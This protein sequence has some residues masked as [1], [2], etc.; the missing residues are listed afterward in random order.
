[1]ALDGPQIQFG[2]RHTLNAQDRTTLENKVLPT[3]CKWVRDFP[4]LR[5]HGIQ[6]LNYWGEPIP[7]YSG[8]GK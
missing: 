7:R 1:M 2:D 6:T 3:A 4:S 8:D 5:A